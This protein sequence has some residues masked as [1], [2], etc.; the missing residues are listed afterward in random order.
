MI[1]RWLINKIMDPLPVW[2]QVAIVFVLFGAIGWDYALKREDASFVLHNHTD[3]PI[4][5][6]M[7]GD[8][9]VGNGRAFNGFSTGSGVICCAKLEENPVMVKW[10]L[11][12]TQDQYDAGVR[13][14]DRRALVVV[15]ERNQSEAYL[16]VHI[17]PENEVRLFWSGTWRSRFQIID[18]KEAQDY[19][20]DKSGQYSLQE[21]GSFQ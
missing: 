1:D 19:E 20:I 8:V 13:S 18:G 9:W 11:S 6:T 3:R 10:R 12:V 16:H 21:F 14:E 5:E 2:L 17:Y 7:V 15:P 4:S